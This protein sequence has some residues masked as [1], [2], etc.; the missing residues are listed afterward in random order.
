MGIYGLESRLEKAKELIS[1]GDDASLR[2]A[3]LE[4]RYCFELIAYRN[5]EQ[6]GD[7]F[8][9]GMATE[10]KPNVIVKTLASFDPVTAQ[11]GRLS[12]AAYQ[13]GE[14][15]PSEF[16]DL[17]ET[18][19]IP[20]KQ[21]NKFYQTLGSYLHLPS[22]AKNAKPP[23]PLTPET[24]TGIIK[25][26]EDVSSATIVMAV[27][28]VRKATCTCSNTLYVGESEF[29]TNDLVI[30]GNTMC[31][32]LWAKNITEDGEKVLSPVNSFGIKCRCGAQINLQP[33]RA[34][35]PFRCNNCNTRQKLVVSSIE[36]LE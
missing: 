13:P 31:N 23:K 36:H 3:C 26:L 35:L 30:C 27:K 16:I 29:E 18:K 9:G 24:F 15:P 7:E 22:P 33:E 1:R 34:W 21:F 4:L 20:W 28:H 10:W 25:A 12:I 19:A 32:K 17:G 5:R 11:S 8:P 14:T 2:Y 6:Y